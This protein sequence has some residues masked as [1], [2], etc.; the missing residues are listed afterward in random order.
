MTVIK[1]DT[2]KLTLAEILRLLAQLLLRLSGKNGQEWYHAFKRFLRREH[3]WL[4]TKW[5]IW[6]V[7]KVGTKKP[8]SE[9]EQ[10]IRDR[11]FKI[12]YSENYPFDLLTLEDQLEFNPKEENVYFT[13]VSARQLGLKVN[14][15]RRQ[16]LDVSKKHGLTPCLSGDA[17]EIAAY[18]QEVLTQ[19][20]H[21][22]VFAMEPVT[23]KG[24]SMFV[25]G[26]YERL[27]EGYSFCYHNGS[28]TDV[29]NYEP[30]LDNEYLFR[31]VKPL[32]FDYV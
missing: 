26:N 28:L 15:T 18:G 13:L 21:S 4:D 5:K 8:L 10:M 31:I 25:I 30:N 12:H 27:K 14:W 29:M 22:V 9:L 17:I 2:Q 24:H 19:D 3:P 11:G 23:I 6:T 20:K 1:N 16:L 32:N 7:A